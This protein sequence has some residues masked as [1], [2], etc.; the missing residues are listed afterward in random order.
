VSRA[1]RVT[2]PCRCARRRLSQAPGGFEGPGE[3]APAAPVE[4]PVG[5]GDGDDECPG[6][7]FVGPTL[8]D[9]VMVGVSVGVDDGDFVG[10]ELEADGDGLIAWPTWAGGGKLS[11]GLPCNAAVIICCQVSAG[12]PPP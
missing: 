3:A 10:D 11:T 6:G 4:E 2:P 7:V 1:H 8:G 5:V 9:T 12:R